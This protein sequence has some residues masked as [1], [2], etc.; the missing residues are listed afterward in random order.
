MSNCNHDCHTKRINA[1]D[2]P[3][4]CPECIPI[5]G[6]IGPT[7]PVGRMGPTGPTGPKGPTGD[8]GPTGPAGNTGPTGPRGCPGDTGPTG[9]IGPTGDTGPTGPRGYPGDTGPTGPTGPV[10]DVGPTGPRGCPGD[11]GPTG[12]TGPVGGVGPTGP[13]GA[14]GGVGPIGPTGPVGD[15]GP[16]GPTGPAGPTGAAGV[17]FTTNNALAHHIATQEVEKNDAVNFSVFDIASSDGSI[18]QAGNTGFA[19]KKGRYLVTFTADCSIDGTRQDIRTTLAINGN[20][21][22]YAASDI[23]AI[24]GRGFRTL[25]HTIL[26]IPATSPQVLSVVNTSESNSYTN[27]SLT[28]VKLS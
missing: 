23:S 18:T 28:L 21:I 25:V 8:I 26:D 3:G 9:P 10:G 5:C 4:C 12:P 19:L 6:M 7:G 17:N 20:L 16:T 22:P 14:A 27:S 2:N 11:T 24:S 13:T 15:T 1:C